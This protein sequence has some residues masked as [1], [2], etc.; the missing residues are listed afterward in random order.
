MNYDIITVGGGL[1]GATFGKAMAEHGVRVLILERDKAFRDRVRGEGMHP[2]GVTEARELG[3][4]ETLLQSC[5]FEVPR[6]SRSFGPLSPKPR[7]LVATSPHKTGELDFYHPDMQEVLLTAAEAAGAEARR[8]ATVTRV[9]P[10]NPAT[11]HFRRNG[12]EEVLHAR[13]VVGADGRNSKV[14]TW[15]QFRVR[16]DPRRV[17]IAGLLFHGLKQ[18][19]DTIHTV[20]EPS[21]GQGAFTF[22]LGRQRFRSYFCYHKRT[23]H[24][25][26]SGSQ[27][28]PRFIAACIETGMPGEWYQNAEAGGPLATFEASDTWVDHPYRSSIALVGDAA[29]APDPSWGCG[30][31]LALRDV[32][33]LRDHLTA[34]DDWEVACHA[35]ADEHDEYYGA[36]H[37]VA[38]WLT[39]MLYEVGPDADALRNRAFPYLAEEPQRWPDLIGLGPDSPSDEAARRRFFA[40]D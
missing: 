35:Y 38:G 25:R 14:R 36:L 34:N 32:R 18:P 21:L 5:G 12:R 7:D 24:Q 28:V 17:M 3:I 13:L 9:T 8:G 23:E 15:G 39:D 10:G 31:S 1:A 40:E 26:L 22:P 2:W 29:A 20:I 6:W 30:L 11:I 33:V 37:R 4:Y 19:E 16:Q 27:D